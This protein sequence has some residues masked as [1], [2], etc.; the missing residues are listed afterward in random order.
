MSG[1]IHL[2]NVSLANGET[3]GYREREG[4]TE[5]LLLTHRNMT[6]S[7]HWDVLR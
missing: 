6:S 4:G 5:H 3:L 1:F 7:K 2:K